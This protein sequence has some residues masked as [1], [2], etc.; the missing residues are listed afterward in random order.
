MTALASDIAPLKKY[1]SPYPRSVRQAS[2]VDNRIYI[3]F[4]FSNP[5]QSVFPPLSRI[6]QTAF[7][8]LCNQLFY[9]F[10]RI[11]VQYS[12]R[13]FLY[14]FHRFFQQIQIRIVK[15]VARGFYI[16]LNRNITL[17]YTR[18]QLR[19]Y[20]RHNPP[21]QKQ[22]LILNII[23]EYISIFVNNNKAINAKRSDKTLR[24]IIYCIL[25]R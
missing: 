4:H 22:C 17:V 24:F 7:F 25:L 1:D 2:V 16:P 12:T 9:A 20:S 21:L 15:R 11:Y 19:K 14:G 5:P 3:H 18:G 10:L 23:K 6:L 13:L 8:A